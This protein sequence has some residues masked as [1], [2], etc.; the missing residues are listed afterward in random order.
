MDW[1]VG[2]F[3]RWTLA[4]CGPATRAL[5]HL[6]ENEEV[7][8]RSI[9]VQSAPHLCRIGQPVFADREARG[10]DDTEP[11]PEGEE[12]GKVHLFRHATGEQQAPCR[13]VVF[14]DDVGDS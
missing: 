13:L 3:Y 2:V 5:A 12:G 10:G 4:P 8:G 1:K 6:R 14:G 9:E 11:T 7:L